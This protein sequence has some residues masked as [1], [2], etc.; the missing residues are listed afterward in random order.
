MEN[1]LW[2]YHGERGRFYCSGK[3]GPYGP[4]FATGDTIGCCLNFINN[5]VLYTKN[6]MNLGDYYLNTNTLLFEGK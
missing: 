2:G 1:D 3:V 6:G 4:L 5:T